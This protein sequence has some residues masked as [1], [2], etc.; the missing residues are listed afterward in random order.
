MDGAR[1]D[2]G[3]V[4]RRGHARRWSRF[5]RGC[6]TSSSAGPYQSLSVAAVCRQSRGKTYGPGPRDCSA[7]ERWYEYSSGRSLVMCSRGTRPPVREG[8]SKSPTH[9][10][11]L[12]VGLV[13]SL[14]KVNRVTEPRL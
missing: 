14:R 7:V 8:S 5:E 1:A 10:P 9:E 6:P 13:P 3:R 2:A 12:T 11:F 4:A